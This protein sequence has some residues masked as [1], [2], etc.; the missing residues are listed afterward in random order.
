MSRC[1]VPCLLAL[2]LS[3]HAGAAD[4][5]ATFTVH[6]ACPGLGAGEV[7]ASVA[8][9]M[10][11]TV[12][13]IEHV[14][15][16][17][18]ESR[19]GAGW[20]VVRFDGRIAAPE[21]AERLRQAVATVRPQLPEDVEQP[22]I[23]RGEPGAL[24]AFVLAV[25]SERLS[26]AE[27][28]HLAERAVLPAVQRV[29]GVRLAQ[30]KG[31]ITSGRS[32]HLDLQRIAAHGL[33]AGEVAD[34]IEKAGAGNAADDALA[35]LVL[36][37]RDG[38]AVRLRDV[39]ALQETTDARDIALL[40]G[41]PGVLLAVHVE[42]DSDVTAAHVRR[43][44]PG[45]LPAGVEVG[46]AADLRG[47][48]RRGWALVELRLPVGASLEA[49]DRVVAEAC[50][51]L[52]ESGMK[53][54]IA[55]DDEARDHVAILIRRPEGKGDLADV[56]RALARLAAASTRVAELPPEFDSEPFSARVALTGPDME[57]LR[58]WAEAAMRRAAEDEYLR[59]LLIAPPGGAPV[60]YFNIAREKATELGIK[61]AAVMR[62]LTLLGGNCQVKWGQTAIAIHAGR[63]PRVA[64]VEALL[65]RHVRN[66]AGEL[67]PL[68]GVVT[69]RES[70]ESPV[71]HRMDGHRAVLLTASP[72]GLSAKG[73]SSQLR[74]A[75][76]VAGEIMK[77]GIEYRARSLAE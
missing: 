27:L 42:P 64:D 56:R 31:A 14:A 21:A 61:T 29:P 10:L 1:L 43:A 5:P 41:R 75:A 33:T 20:I 38:A 30:I 59:D 6:V 51:I 8:E 16:A 18:A 73:A 77:L 66:A 50:A 7:D 72:G 47:A 4:E 68:A 39:A 36:R 19:H 74:A 37:E 70:L 49:K 15:M 67:V 53:E 54:S 32:V 62:E 9:P 46:I 24:P 48:S 13:G 22:R 17:R 11:A 34:A 28:T 71:I 40:D 63:D 65:G 35:E 60:I 26:R 2:A 76:A 25:R 3:A 23:H 45:D 57:T 58:R 55:I 69:A 12:R 44:L 52:G